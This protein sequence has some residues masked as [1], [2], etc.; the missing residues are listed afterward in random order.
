MIFN[1]NG[2]ILKEYNTANSITT[3]IGEIL[4]DMT[5]SKFDIIVLLAD[6]SKNHVTIE[7]YYKFKNKKIPLYKINTLTE[8]SSLLK[9]LNSVYLKLNG[10]RETWQYCKISI[11]KDGKINLDFDYNDDNISFDDYKRKNIL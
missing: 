3:K 8:I 11:N 10:N 9:D 4:L 6:V 7:G 5:P 2:E 1:E